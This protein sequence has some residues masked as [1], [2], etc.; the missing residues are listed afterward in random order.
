MVC[1]QESPPGG[2]GGGEPWSWGAARVR[3]ACGKF[4][5]SAAKFEAVSRKL[6]Q[7]PFA[8]RPG[9]SSYRG[10]GLFLHERSF[11]VDSRRL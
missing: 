11:P 8:L 10:E 4:A 7:Q 5:A 1:E 3:G 6:Q 2:G 9:S